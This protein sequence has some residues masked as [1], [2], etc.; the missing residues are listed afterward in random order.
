MNLTVG[1]KARKADIVAHARAHPE[2][3]REW[4]RQV[5]DV[6]TLEGYDFSDD[7]LGVVGWDVAGQQFAADHPI[8]AVSSVETQDDLRALLEE[9]LKLFRRFVELQGGWRL[10]WTSEQ[11]PKPEEAAQLLFLGMAQAYFRLLGVELDREVDLGRGP[12][13]FKL[14]KG[15]TARMLLEFKKAENGK[16]WNGLDSQLPSYL[17]SDDCPEGWFVALRFSSTESAARKFVDLPKRVKHAAAET[18]KTIK[19]FAVDARPKKSASKLD[20]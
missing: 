14:S 9:L 6:A 12:V 16:F 11:R 18:G 17:A 3:I 5:A 8:T 4:A 15:T 13:D 10:L 7:P 20:A 2:R 19:F 1:T